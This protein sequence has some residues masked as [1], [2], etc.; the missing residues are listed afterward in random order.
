MCAYA[1]LSELY[2]LSEYCGHGSHV[3]Y[4]WTQWRVWVCVCEIKRLINGIVCIYLYLSHKECAYFYRARYVY[5]G[6]SEE[7]SIAHR[8]RCKVRFMLKYLY[9]T[10]TRI[11]LLS[12]FFVLCVLSRSHEYERR[13]CTFF[14]FGVQKNKYTHIFYACARISSMWFILCTLLVC[15][16][17]A[18]QSFLCSY[19]KTCTYIYV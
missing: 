6:R 1:P 12:A 4:V 19:I 16:R 5:A 2:Y 10:W 7:T 8:S 9:Y 13:L 11:T 3:L 14:A 17:S 18:R 15:A